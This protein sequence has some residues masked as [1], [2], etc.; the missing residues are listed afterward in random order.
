[1]FTSVSVNSKLYDEWR[2]L[3][4]ELFQMI[5]FHKDYMRYLEELIDD[6][7][8]PPENAMPLFEQLVENNNNLVYLMDVI[9]DYGGQV[10][11]NE[12]SEELNNRIEKTRL[13]V[14]E[15]ELRISRL[16]SPSTMK[17]I[18]LDCEHLINYWMGQKFPGATS[19]F[20]SREDIIQLTGNQ[21]NLL[22][23]LQRFKNSIEEYLNETE[24]YCKSITDINPSIMKY[25]GYRCEATGIFKYFFYNNKDKES[26]SVS[27]TVMLKPDISL[28][29]FGQNL[30]CKNFDPQITL[31]PG[32][33]RIVTDEEDKC[34]G[35]YE[36][37]DLNK[38]WIQVGEKRSLVTMNDKGWTFSINSEKDA[39]I[40]R[41]EECERIKGNKNG[42]D[43]EKRIVVEISDNIELKWYPFIIATP[44]L[45]F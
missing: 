38:M 22:S 13:L 9:K 27:S 26:F 33:R 23:E 10:I 14:G 34:V 11:V 31:V 6:G 19:D 12:N 25:T 45:A 18:L 29:G 37:I 43:T 21:G 41:L 7:I 16:M 40:I 44:M 20:S 17:I 32:V 42:F 28:V 5:D 39:Q 3:L 24:L 4:R 1:M 8:I 35:Y 15:L 2:V 36:Y 30:F